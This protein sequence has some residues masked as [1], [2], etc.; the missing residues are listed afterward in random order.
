MRTPVFILSFF[1]LPIV[2]Y[3]GNDDSVFYAK[4]NDLIRNSERMYKL[5]HNE[6]PLFAEIYNLND[7][8]LEYKIAKLNDESPVELYLDKDVKQWLFP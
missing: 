8:A 2:V 3:G 5:S 4:I 7:F 1:L 6:N